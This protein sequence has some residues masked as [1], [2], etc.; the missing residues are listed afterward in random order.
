[1]RRGAGQGTTLQ[2]VVA[3]SVPLR[4]M[5]S[6]IHPCLQEYSHRITLPDFSKI[7]TLSWPFFDQCRWCFA[8]KRVHRY[9]F[10]D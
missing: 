4:E 9:Q 3:V 2:R 1:M 6:D 7:T 10:P 5:F 8:L